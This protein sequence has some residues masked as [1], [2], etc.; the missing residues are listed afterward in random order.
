MIKLETIE[1]IAGKETARGGEAAIALHTAKR[2]AML[3]TFA[4]DPASN[5]GPDRD[6][7]TWPDDVQSQ[8]VASLFSFAVPYLSAPR[9]RIGFRVRDTSKSDS[10]IVDAAAGPEASA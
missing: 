5:D 4:A 3:L 6:P 10:P 2:G 7:K 9:G 8:D 1:R